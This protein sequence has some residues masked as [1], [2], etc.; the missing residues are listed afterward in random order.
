MASSSIGFVLPW[1]IVERGVWQTVS[2][3]TN[4]SHYAPFFYIVRLKATYCNAALAATASPSR[5]E[6]H[7]R[8]V[9]S[10]HTRKQ[11]AASTVTQF[12]G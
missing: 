6:Q 9:S 3:R 8:S 7:R 5:P 12:R 11:H 10:K 4:M 1:K 2:V